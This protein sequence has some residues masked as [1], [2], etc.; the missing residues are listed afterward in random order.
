M[1][2][3]P[4]R[5]ATALTCEVCGQLP[6]PRKARLTLAKLSAVLPIELLLHALVI[7]LHPP[8]LLTVTV[9]AVT[10]T[11]LVIWV[12][13]PSAMR[14]LTRWLH[15]PA[16]HVRE[17]LHAAESLWRLRVTLSDEPG[18]LEAVTHELARLNASILSLHVHP[19]EHGARDEFVIGA[20]GAVRQQE[21]VRAAE[22]A[23]GVDVHVWD[24]TALALVDGQ[25][26][27]LT[28]AAAVGQRPEE[29]PSAV[30]EMLGAQLLTDREWLTHEHYRR[31]AENGTILR[32]PSP[33][34]ALFIFARPDEPF[35]P[36]ERAR[37]NRLAQIAEAAALMPTATCRAAPMNATR[38]DA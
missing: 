37:A 29:L 38:P 28:L 31:D 15:A 14:L 25:T 7:H 5:T 19:L 33:W 22:R 24:T 21:L 2:H 9:L 6:H 11:V 16:I 13:E 34:N 23:G 35:T 10:T 36:A 1:N 27:A 32:I 18:S 12:V 20:A 8:Y 17:R 26:K 4:V 3:T 30:A